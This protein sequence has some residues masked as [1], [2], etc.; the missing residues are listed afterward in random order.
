MSGCNG[1]T[2][3]VQNEGNV[4]DN[5]CS[6]TEKFQN[7]TDDFPKGWRGACAVNKA[8]IGESSCKEQG[9]CLGNMQDIGNSSCLGYHACVENEGLIDD[10]SWYVLFTLAF[11]IS[12]YMWLV[13]ITSL[14]YLL[15]AVT[16]L[17]DGLLAC[18]KNSGDIGYDSCSTTEK[19]PADFDGDIN[20]WAGACMLNNATIGDSSCDQEGSCYFNY[21]EVG[22]SSCLGYFSC[23]FNSGMI[24]NESWY[25]NY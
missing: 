3:C 5:S 4:G 23:Y 9:S 1:L 10:E 12:V 11:V 6:T 13:C 2:A 14:L 24:G 15:C 17:S 20:Q 22:N 16:L 18:W 21:Q 19:I 25:V 8:T 7:E